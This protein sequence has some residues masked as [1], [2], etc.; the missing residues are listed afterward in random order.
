M[1]IADLAVVPN[2]GSVELSE[3]QQEMFKSARG[4]A[5]QDA[6]ADDPNFAVKGKAATKTDEGTEGGGES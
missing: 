2:G 1:S 3:E 5:V 4:M 6:L